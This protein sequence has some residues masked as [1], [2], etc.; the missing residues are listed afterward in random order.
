M[1]GREIE[2]KTLD[3]MTRV[4]G[5]DRASGLF[6]IVLLLD[7]LTSVRDLRQWLTA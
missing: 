7:E 1:D 3:L 6:E 5:S 4:I 2:A